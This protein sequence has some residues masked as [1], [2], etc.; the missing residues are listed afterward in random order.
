MQPHVSLIIPV[1]NAEPFLERCLDSAAAQTEPE[2][3]IICVDDAST[4][5][6]AAMLDARAGA[7]SRFRVVHRP[8]NGGESAARNHGV[9]LARGEYLAFLDHDDMLEPDACRLLYEAAR[10]TGADIVRG[11]VKTVDYEGQASLSPLQLHKDIHDTSR[12][13]FNIDWWSAIYRAGLVQGKLRFDES[14]ALGA[15][16]VFL[17]EALIATPRLR[18]VDDLV[19]THFLLPDSGASLTLSQEKIRSTIASRL[20]I[21]ELLHGAHI[22]VADPDG[23]IYKL[24][25]CFENGV[26]VLYNRCRDSESRALCCDYLYA[27]KN[28]HRY[29][30]ALLE[31]LKKNFEPLFPFFARDGKDFLLTIVKQYA[32][33]HSGAG[34]SAM[35]RGKLRCL[36][37]QALAAGR[38]QKRGR[39]PAPA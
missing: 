14:Y 19:Y 7:D 39:G 38:P 1:H 35:V 6:S 31:A 17:T 24:W 32:D 5:A 10:A 27:L 9:A 4:D 11:R 37:A 2:L 36:A 13:F 22:D 25:Q 26:D 20:R 18:C 34:S 23:Y 12:F 30:Q 8:V 29:P 3:E 21:V 28:I 33:L 15:D 16:M